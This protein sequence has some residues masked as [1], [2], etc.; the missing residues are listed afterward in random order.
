MHLGNDMMLC[1]DR[2]SAKTY[3]CA[4]FMALFA[5]TITFLM[6]TFK[7]LFDVFLFGVTII[8]LFLP[9]MIMSLLQI[10]VIIYIRY[11]VYLRVTFD[12]C[13][14]EFSLKQNEH[15]NCSIALGRE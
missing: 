6:A 5:A 3:S 4:A 2:L 15:N 8:S 1:T 12:L 10:H 14:R 9:Q 13:I 7:I 11:R